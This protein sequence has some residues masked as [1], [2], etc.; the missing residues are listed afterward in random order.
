M[1]VGAAGSKPSIQRARQLGVWGI[2]SR[3]RF[4]RAQP[5]RNEVIAQCF[6][7]RRHSLPGVRPD[8]PK[9]YGSTLARVV[10]LTLKGSQELWDRPSGSSPK[11]SERLKGFAMGAT[12]QF[13]HKSRKNRI[14]FRVDS[15]NCL[16][17]PYLEPFFLTAGLV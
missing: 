5:H 3:Q 14:G 15:P 10:I 16:G 13:A 4:C 9:S 8:I 7:Q 11:S 17:D 2:D 1:C 12:V 6:D